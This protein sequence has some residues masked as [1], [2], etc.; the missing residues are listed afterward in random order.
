MTPEQQA[1]FIIAQA[2]VFNAEIAGMVAENQWRT[3]RG[4]VIAYA[5]DAFTKATET[6][7]ALL[8]HNNCIEFFRP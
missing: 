3:H 8:T 4:E 5:E 7:G 2:A 1:A 6:T